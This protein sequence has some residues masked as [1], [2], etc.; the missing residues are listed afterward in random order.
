VPKRNAL[1]R[2]LLGAL[3]AAAAVVATT[4]G[5]VASAHPA[6]AA[7]SSTTSASHRTKGEPNL[8]QS[9]SILHAGDRRTSSDGKYRLRM[10]RGG[11]LTLLQT[12]S[13]EVIWATDTEGRGAWAAMQTDGNLVVYSRLR[14]VLWASMT[15]APGAHLTVQDDGNI[16]IYKRS[17]PLWNRF[18]ESQIVWP[19][20]R[21]RSGVQV[22]S[23]SGQFRF[24][25][26]MDGN[27]VLYGPGLVVKWA[28]ATNSP[29]STARMTLAGQLEVYGPTG[30]LIWTSGNPISPGAKLHVQD[31]GNVVIF[32]ETGQPL[33]H[34]QTGTPG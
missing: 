26:Q 33:W 1:C 15:H 4:G 30:A 17:K 20:H 13:R 5:I 29:G 28:L 31:D 14:K 21:L 18:S 11:N 2:S 3:V 23:A 6:A 27:L 12:R 19:G 8:L 34:T 9:G 24:A 10:Q 16:V 25:M 32:S 22:L 7:S